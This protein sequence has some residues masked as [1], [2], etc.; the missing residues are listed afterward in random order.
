MVTVVYFLEVAP[1]PAT[2][3][4][5]M[6]DWRNWRPW[7]CQRLMV[8]LM[9]AMTLSRTDI[10]GFETQ[11]ISIQVHAELSMFQTT[12]APLTKLHKLACALLTVI[13]Y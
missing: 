11:Y 13:R 3:E 5:R 9:V 12:S 6:I 1:P 8:M 2:A 10:T 4:T 7:H